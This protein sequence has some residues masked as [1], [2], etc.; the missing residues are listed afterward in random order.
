M[1]V[2]TIPVLQ[3]NF[4]Y[5]LF[6]VAT[7]N[8]GV[9]DPVDPQKVLTVVQ[10]LGATQVSLMITH[11]HW[12]HAGG[13]EKFLKL[14]NEKANVYGGDERIPKLTHLLSDGESFTVTA[15]LLCNVDR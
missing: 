6:D 12:D 9:I 8:V 2:H 5:V 13:N 7:R 4:S 10:S 15:K 1:Q 14:Y 11:H 3:D